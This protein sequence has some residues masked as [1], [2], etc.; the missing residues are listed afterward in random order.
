MDV[1]K[2]ESKEMEND[3]KNW[4]SSISSGCQNLS[5][6][7]NRLPFSMNGNFLFWFQMEYKLFYMWRKYNRNHACVQLR[8]FDARRTNQND[9]S[10]RAIFIH[11]WIRLSNNA[12]C[13]A[14]SFI[15]SILYCKILSF[16]SNSHE[17]NAIIK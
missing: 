15:S 4:K 7:H 13:F 17:L 1:I 2:I 5:P 14:H 12:H 11:I 8:E 9:C 3:I 10:N 6:H 16:R